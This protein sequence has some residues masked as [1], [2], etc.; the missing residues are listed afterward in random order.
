ML[1]GFLPLLLICQT[2][3][4]KALLWC[5]HDILPIPDS[6]DAKTTENQTPSHIL[7]DYFITGPSFKNLHVAFLTKWP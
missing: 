7:P 4:H 3:S 6:Y 1:S 5:G 2:L